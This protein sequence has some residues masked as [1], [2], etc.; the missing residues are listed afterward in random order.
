MANKTKNIDVIQL[1]G[2]T[3]AKIKA[4]SYVPKAR[5]II[6]ATDTREM[7]IGDGVTQLKS[8]S[9]TNSSILKRLETMD[10]ELNKLRVASGLV[11][12]EECSWNEIAEVSQIG[13][14]ETAFKVGDEKTIALSTGEQ[15]TLVILGF[16]HDDKAS[17]GGKA[18]ITFGM[19]NL[20]ATK[21]P[22]NSS[23]N[24]TGGWDRSVMRTSTMKTLLGQLPADL[25]AAIKPVTKKTSAGLQDTT[26][27]STTDSLFLLSEIEVFGSATYS[28][29][30]EGTQYDYYKNIANTDTARIKKLSNGSGSANGWWLRSPYESNSAGFCC[31]YAVGN[32][33]NY[34]AGDSAGVAFGFCV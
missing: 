8:L 24:N 26:I 1:K 18:G 14:A 29:S 7:F 17:G 32:V 16:N 20:L 22:M 10:G 23:S 13:K 4:S 3:S 6:V 25:Q 21:Y 30:G 12:L 15:V 27:N 2:G 33:Y 11:T 28:V 31:V 9:S 19:K 34:Y 5:E